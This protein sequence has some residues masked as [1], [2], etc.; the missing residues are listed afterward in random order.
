MWTEVPT[1]NAW[2]K[3][4]LLVC[5]F[6]PA[7]I[8]MVMSISSNLNIGLRHVLPVYP[9]LFVGVGWI[10]ALAW[11]R[12]GWK[13]VGTAAAAIGVG[14]AVESFAI[15]P[16]YLTFFNVAAGGQRGGLY[17]LG[18]SNLD[19]GQDLPLLAEWQ[20]ANPD[21]PLYLSYF[22]MV[23]PAFYRI[24]YLNL[25][26]GYELN[27]SSHQPPPRSVTAISATKLQGVYMNEGLMP[28]YSA[29]LEYEPSAVL[30]G[31]IYVY[32]FRQPL[33]KMD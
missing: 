22:G 2:M 5:L 11:R 12:W 32:D 1:P 26:G 19:W 23:D 27:P 13:I 6:L 20:K 25:P 31:T 4:W 16:D 8:F 18:D 17:R 3:A 30:G 15:A 10:I 33:K 21:V 24:R 14:L 9:P 29:F 7:T 28:L